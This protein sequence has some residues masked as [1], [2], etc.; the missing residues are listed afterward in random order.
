M[1]EKEYRD[2]EGR[3]LILLANLAGQNIILG[4]LYAPNIEDPEFFLQLKKIILDFG[5][6]PMILGGDYNQVLDVFLDRSGQGIIRPS[7]TQEAIKSLCKDT[8]LH[9]VWRLLNT[10]ARDY[11]FFSHRHSVYSRIDYFL[12]SHALIENTGTCNIGTIAMTDHAPIDLTVA[13]GE[14]QERSK[15]WRMNTSVLQNENMCAN[16]KS[17]IKTFFEINN[18]T[19]N[20]ITVWDTFKSY[21]LGIII[22]QTAS[23]K[24]QDKIKVSQY[25]EKIKRLESEFW[26]QTNNASLANL[27]KTKYELNNILTKK[28]NILSID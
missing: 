22:Q 20:Q 4:N 14:A 8:G 21:I 5:N 12:I 15:G 18:G 11:T 23:T 16:L 3:I 25:E 27:I 28:Q 13:L 10:D 6:F 19:A 17:H 1:V 26:E 2:K 24:K 7:R 9:D